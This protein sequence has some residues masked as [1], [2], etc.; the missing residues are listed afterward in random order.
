MKKPLL[1]R[2]VIVIFLV[3]GIGAYILW[4]QQQQPAPAAPAQIQTQTQE[5]TTLWEDQAG[6]SFQYPKVLSFDKHDED[7]KN[8]AHIEFTSA[9]HSGRLIVWV[10]DTTYSNLDAWAANTSSIDTTLGGLPAKKIIVSTPS[11]KIIVGTISDQIL[12]TIEAE[13]AEGD[14]YW[15]TV[16]DTIASSFAFVPIN[17]ASYDEEEVVE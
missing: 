5:E 15:T 7:Q 1:I 3:G 9:T 11:R 12:F 2:I 13:P 14:F 17:G 16:S 4:K 10:K 8:Y 6:F